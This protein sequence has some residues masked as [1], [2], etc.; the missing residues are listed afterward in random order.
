M[1]LAAASKGLS[2]L[3]V[4]P[5]PRLGRVGLVAFWD[6]DD[7]LD[8]FLADDPLPPHWRTAWHTRLAPVRSH[9]TWPGLDSDVAHPRTTS[10]DGPAVV[11]TLGQ[12]RLTQTVQFLRTSA[13]ASA[14][15]IEAPGFHDLGDG[16]GP[17]AVRLHLLTVGLLRRPVGLR[18]AAVTLIAPIPTPSLPTLKGRFIMVLG[19]PVRFRPIRRRRKPFGPKPAA[20]ARLSPLSVGCALPPAVLRWRGPR[21]SRW[22]TTGSGPGD[23][24]LELTGPLASREEGRG[25]SLD[26]RGPRST[27][28]SPCNLRG[29]PCHRPSALDRYRV[30]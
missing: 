5:V 29:A 15:A 20:R 24:T 23:L 13:I 12:L 21:S 6:S 10:H 26:R 2:Q 16:P 28:A 7:A 22:L 18:L 30:G 11:L 8:Q 4:L 27:L 9:G 19:L 17:T 3:P 25:F 1:W 14:G